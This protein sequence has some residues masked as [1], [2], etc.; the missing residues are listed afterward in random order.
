MRKGGIF[1]LMNS[2]KI[3]RVIGQNIAAYLDDLARL[4]IEVFREY[5][6]L[7]QGDKAYEQHYLRR[8]VDS[9]ASL[10]ILVFDDAQVVGASTALPLADEV[11]E[12]KRPFQEHGYRIET[13]FY[14][15][16]SVLLKPYRGQGIGH[17]FFDERERY[18]RQLQR[19]D[20]CTFCAV[21]RPE[22][23]PY[24]PSNYYPLAPFWQKRG[25]EK[26]PELHTEFEWQEIHEASAS[27]KPMVFWLKRL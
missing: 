3:E 12:F 9:Q 15:G 5:P 20:Y 25:F 24:R 6:Y 17:R 10:L 14:F 18:A 2:V 16:E 4:R 22:N 7:Y 8:Y 23:H 27:M 19:F 21:Q 26:R 11:T 1:F 13:I